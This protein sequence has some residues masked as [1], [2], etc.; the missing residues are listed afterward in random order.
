MRKDACLVLNELFNRESIR[1]SE[2][3]M[4]YC[5]GMVSRD[6][7]SRVLDVLELVQVFLR[8]PVDDS[9]AVVQM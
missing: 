2:V 4:M 5:Q 8:H 9:T 1:L 3:G 7:G 6:T